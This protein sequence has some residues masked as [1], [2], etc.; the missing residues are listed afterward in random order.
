MAGWGTW[1]NAAVQAYG[2]YSAAQ[3]AKKAEKAQ[4]ESYSTPYGNEYIAPMIRYILD[5][6]AKVYNQRQ[7]IYGGPQMGANVM[8]SILAG[9]PAGYSGVGK[10]GRPI[11]GTNTGGG[12][13]VGSA[14]Q[15]NWS[16]RISQ[17]KTPEFDSERDPRVSNMTRDELETYLNQM[18]M[19]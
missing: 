6:E 12:N 7:G 5:Q 14:A 15:P 4:K 10:P 8:A 17:M 19:G 9:V 11:L 3:E 1:V 13:Y 2:A 16:D 18:R